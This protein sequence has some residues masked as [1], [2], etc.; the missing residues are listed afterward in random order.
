MLAEMNRQVL[1]KLGVGSHENATLLDVGCGIGTASIQ[2]SETLQ[3]SFFYGVNIS[4][5][6]ISYGEKMI[7]QQNLQ[8]RIKLLLADFTKVPME[9]AFFDAAFAIE[10]ACYSKGIEKKGF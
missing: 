4:E 2:M 3:G 6:Q 1:A 5:R 8:N 7:Q 10:S 9:D